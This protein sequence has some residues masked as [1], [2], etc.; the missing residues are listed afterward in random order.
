[1]PAGGRL[2]VSPHRALHLYNF[3]VM[4][5][6]GL[7]PQIVRLTAVMAPVAIRRIIRGVDAGH[8]AR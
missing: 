7:R 3:A 8:A 4:W 5:V 2:R 6:P 1:M